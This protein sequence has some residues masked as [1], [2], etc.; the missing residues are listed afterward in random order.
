MLQIP[1]LLRNPDIQG[2]KGKQ[3]EMMSLKTTSWTVEKAATSTQA[4]PPS[5]VCSL[6]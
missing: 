6:T 2:G 5:S 1:I 4:I 3:D